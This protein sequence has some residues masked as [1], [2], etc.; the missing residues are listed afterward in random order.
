M[1]YGPVDHLRRPVCCP[2]SHSIYSLCMNKRTAIF[3]T[4][5]ARYKKLEAE[6]EALKTEREIQAGDSAQVAELLK[7][8]AE[9]QDEKTRQAELHREEV[10][11]LQAQIAAQAEAHQTEV[12][13]L[14]S[15][16]SSRADEKIQLEGEVKKGKELAAQL[17][18]R[19]TSAELEDV[20]KIA[21]FRVVQRELIK[22]DNML[23]KFFPTSLEHAQEAVKVARQ[24]RDPAA[25]AGEPFEYDLVD[26]LVSIASRVR[27]LR[28]FGVDLLNAVIRAFRVLWPGEEAPADIL[29]LAKRLLETESRLSDWRESAA[30]IGTDEAL[31]FVLLWYDGINLDMLQSMRAG[32]PYLTD[33][34]L[35]AKRKERAYSFIQY[36]DVHTFVEGPTSEANAEMTDEEEE[37]AAAEEDVV[38]SASTGNAAPSSGANP[39]ISS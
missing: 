14:T 7:R 30:R 37:E 13:Q 23:T 32:S 16:L 19:A 33:P 12:N 21:L 26:Y 8:V 25:A 15:A 27:P 5:L 31:S 18:T 1:Q 9:V 4:L 10:T 6:H 36:A 11:R 34:E 29:T 22:I 28:S 39:S 3:K 17:E 38:E 20:E 24:K 2:H 35:V